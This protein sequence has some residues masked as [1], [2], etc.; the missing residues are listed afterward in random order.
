MG[1]ASSCSEVTS[2]ETVGSIFH[3][4]RRSGT[5][6]GTAEDMTAGSPLTSAGSVESPAGTWRD[7]LQAG[8]I[9]RWRLS[10]LA[11]LNHSDP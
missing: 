6:T 11:S 8:K 10:S 9:V 7:R 2:P 5:Q 1:K 4:T 3:A